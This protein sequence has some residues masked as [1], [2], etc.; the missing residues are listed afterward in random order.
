L[1]TPGAHGTQ[2][3]PASGRRVL[4]WW[5]A[6]RDRIGQCGTI[7]ADR[8]AIVAHQH[9]RHEQADVITSEARLS[10]VEQLASD[11]FRKAPVRNRAG[12]SRCPAAQLAADMAYDSDALRAFLIERGI[13]PVIPNNPTR[14]RLH[15]FDR[16]ACRGRSR[17]ERILQRDPCR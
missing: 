7:A 12:R 3:R 4:R 15:P 5:S 11:G 13:V 17:I 8:Q 10:F 9:L 1:G 2:N 6:L 16:D 14:K